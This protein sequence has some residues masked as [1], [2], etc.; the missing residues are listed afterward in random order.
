MAPRDAIEAL[1]AEGRLAEARAGLVALVETDRGAG[2]VAFVNRCIDSLAGR[3]PAGLVDTQVFVLRTITLEPLAPRLRAMALRDGLNLRI[4]FGE[5]NQFEQEI[6]GRGALPGDVVPEFVV[7]A[8]RLD[9]LAPP[10]VRRYVGTPTERRAAIA[11]QVL[12]RIEHWL[13]RIR[14]RWPDVTVLLHGFEQPAGAFGLAEDRVVDGQRRLVR[15]LNDRLADLCRTR[16]GAYLV[17]IDPALADI[18]RRHAY[19]ARTWAHARLPYSIEGLDA[20]SALLLRFISA[21]KTPRRKCVVLD[22][23]DTL[24]GGILGEDGPEGIALGPDH[25]GSAFVAFQDALLNL[26][27]RGVL[28]ALCT[29]NNEADVLEVLDRHPF[30]VIRREHLAAVRINWQDK[31]A[32]LAELADELNIGLDS[33]IFIDDSSFECDLLRKQLP[34]VQVVQTPTDRLRLARLVTDELRSLDAL[35]WSQED[36]RRGGMYQAQAARERAR[37]AFGSVDDYLRSLEMRLDLAWTGRPQIARVSQ[38]TRKTNQFNLT[39]RRHTEQ[40]I[41]AFVSDGDTYVLHAHLADRFGEHGLTVVL[42]LVREHAALRV[43]TFLMSCRII[44]RRVEDAVMAWVLRFAASLAGVDE[45]VGEYIPTQKNHQ[46]KDFY[47][48][49]GFEA[50]V[51]EGRWRWPVDGRTVPAYPDCF[52]LTLPSGD[53]TE[54]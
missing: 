45:V 7:V 43:D 27:D 21:A 42:L 46:T 22:C 3:R 11:G 17:A 35:G 8:A 38:L 10:L 34:E 26:R 18:G 40:A 12:E 52:V 51:D 4:A 37:E 49:L 15:Q 39:A 24:W 28:L 32:N 33:M 19:D 6:A 13:D 23:D 47:L 25:P 50:T 54:S 20:L 2:A 16:P 44:G 1:M 14:D 53:A 41:E 9:E 48:R 31:V 36:S 30:Q 29:K 5:Y